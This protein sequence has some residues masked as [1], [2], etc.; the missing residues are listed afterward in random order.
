MGI[1]SV[2]PWDIDIKNYVDPFGRPALKP[3]KTVEEQ[4]EKTQT[5]FNQVDP[6]LGAYFNQL[7]KD[8]LVDIPNRKNKRGGAY[9]ANLNLVRKPFV[10]SNS[11]G[12]HND[13]QTLIHESGHAFHTYET[14]HLPYMPQLKC[15]HGNRRSCVHDHGTINLSIP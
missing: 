3:Y 14:A 12:T 10:F 6:A 11:V 7:I 13:V 2:R 4:V 5:I 15:H 1:E 9:C 8:K